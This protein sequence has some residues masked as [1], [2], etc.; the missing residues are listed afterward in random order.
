MSQARRDR[1][2]AEVFAALAS[3]HANRQTSDAAYILA[4]GLEE[5][6]FVRRALRLRVQADVA[7]AW[8][9]LPSEVL[10]QHKIPRGF[11]WWQLEPYIFRALKSIARG[12]HHRWTRYS[13]AETRLE[14]AEKA[15]HRIR[16]DSPTYAFGHR[17]RGDELDAWREEQLSALLRKQGL[18][19]YLTDVREIVMA[20]KKRR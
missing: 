20:R 13:D 9:P 12:E 6:G 5:K 10:V 17:L 19:R 16:R 15:A 4:D 2:A 8:S 1:E 14:L 18:L 3:Q 7:R 11:G